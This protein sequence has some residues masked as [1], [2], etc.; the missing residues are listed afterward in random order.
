M[1]DLSW[2]VLLSADWSDLSWMMWILPAWSLSDRS[3][4]E[5]SLMMMGEQQTHREDTAFVRV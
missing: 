5:S 3:G 4:L 1:V 2:V